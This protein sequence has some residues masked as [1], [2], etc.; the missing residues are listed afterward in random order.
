MARTFTS[1][2][3]FEA[4]TAAVTA[5]PFTIN[6]WFKASATNRGPICIV[7]KITSSSDLFG[8]DLDSGNVRAFTF[9]G[10]GF[11]GA[12]D[13]VGYSTGVWEMGT[14]TWAGVADRRAFL[15]GGNKGT[16]TVSRTPTGLDRTSIGRFGDST[17]LGS[18]QDVD[19]AEIAI[20]NIALSDAEVALL[21]DAAPRAY[22]AFFV[23]PEA[24]VHYWRCLENSI[25]AGLTDVIGGL[26][27]AQISS[28]AIAD[29]V[30]LLQPAPRAVWSAPVAAEVAVGGF[31]P[32]RR[33]RIRYEILHNRG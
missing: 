12:S 20:W 19:V 31:I 28:P 2:D 17:P 14:G 25:T 4:D 1:T 32:M 33:K 6:A 27:L 13:S 18:Q 23:R 26:N 9:S 30:P 16:N 22:S 3:Y 21:Y 15:N 10:A 24:L 8:L 5:V 7:A 29:H 11:E